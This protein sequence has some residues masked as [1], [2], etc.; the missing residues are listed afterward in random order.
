MVNPTK[1]IDAVIDAPHIVEVSPKDKTIKIPVRCELQNNSEHDYVLHSPNED[2]QS[3][4]HVMDEDHRE[5]HREK[6]A[7]KGG[8]G[9]KKDDFRSLT[10][11]SGHS[12]HEVLVFKLK[13]NRLRSGQVIRKML[14]PVTTLL[15]RSG[16]SRKVSHRL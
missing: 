14:K 5:I 11:A 4:W 8:A 9:S 16:L 6:G 1:L 7:G 15:Y 12:S 2:N 10:I 13:A 3:F